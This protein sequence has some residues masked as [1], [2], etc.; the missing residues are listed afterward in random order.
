MT[1]KPFVHGPFLVLSSVLLLAILATAEV[2]TSTPNCFGRVPTIT[3]TPGPDTL[4][5]TAGSDVI[6][7]LGGADTINGM[8]GADYLCGGDGNDTINGGGGDDS[9]SGDAGAD[10]LVGGPGS[11]R[12]LGVGGN[13][14]LKG[15][16]GDD[17]LNGGPGTD[18]ATGGPGTDTC[19]AETRAS[20]EVIPPSGCTNPPRVPATAVATTVTVVGSNAIETRST[21]SLDGEFRRLT[22]MAEVRNATSS[23]I[24]LG[25]AE[26]AVYNAA[27]TRIGTRFVYADADALAPG[28]RT[29]LSETVPS[30][31][32]WD[33]ETNDFPDG[34]ASWK[35]TIGATTGSAG[36]YGHV[37]IRSRL[38]SLSRD[39]AGEVTAVGVAVNSLGRAIDDAYWW[40]VLY[41]TAGRLIN[42]AV[43]WTPEYGELAPGAAR[44]FDAT[45]GSDEP[46]CF[47]SVRWGAAG[48]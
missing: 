2:A 25:E 44:S 26:I 16:D 47:A 3:G 19:V 20:C 9:I 30:W 34:W 48:G 46:T 14:T 23:S 43:G 5:G 22:L 39:S 18:N 4:N 6:V 1:R 36:S 38:S 35:L 21:V 24:R 31:L 29:V 40:V 42:V 33:T 45:M 28:E 27:G 15:Q 17:S 13:D 41:D 11:D 8:G 10:L 12:I 7:G 37:I 32:Y